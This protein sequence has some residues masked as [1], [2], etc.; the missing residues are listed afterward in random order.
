M[1]SLCDILDSHLERTQPSRKLIKFV[2][3]RP[4]HDLRYAVDSS[5]IESETGWKAGFSF[6][7]A[8]SDTIAWYLNNQQ[9]VQSVQSGEYR[10]W[11]EK[12]YDNR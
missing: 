9:W 10:N 12:N 11:I 6:K 4:G 8:L 5:K 7:D 3:D 2:N 1:N